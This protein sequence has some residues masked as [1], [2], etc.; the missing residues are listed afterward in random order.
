MP[1]KREKGRAAYKLLTLN[2]QIECVFISRR[3][4]KSCQQLGGLIMPLECVCIIIMWSKN[5]TTGRITRRE[6]NTNW[7]WNQIQ[8]IIYEYG[9]LKKLWRPVYKKIKVFIMHDQ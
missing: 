1:E 4:R 6:E 8:T 3:G 7:Q 5:K 9:G 2:G